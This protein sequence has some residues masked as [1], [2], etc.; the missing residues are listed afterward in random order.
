MIKQSLFDGI[1]K[2]IVRDKEDGDYAY[3]QALSLKLEYV[4]K[5]VTSGVIACIGEDV[6]RH[7]YSLEHQLVR[8]NSIGEW[9]KAL[10][11]A[12]VGPPAQ[13]FDSNG[14]D[15]VRDLTKRV[16]PQDWQYSAVINLNQAAAEVG[17]GS[18]LG[19]KVA[20]R[21]FFDIG[22]R[23]RNRSRGHGATTNDQC[24]RACSRLA[25]SLDAVVGEFRLFELPW[26]Y[27]HRNLSGKYRVSTLLG[28]TSD[29]DHLK[30]ERDVKLSNGVFLYLGR[31]VHVPLVFSD[32]DVLDIALPNGNHQGGTFESLSYVTNEVAR[33]DGSAWSDTPARLPQSETEGSAVLEP[34]GNTFTNVPP[35]FDGYIP[36]SDLE[37]RL[38]KELLESDR[39]RIISLTGPGGIGKTAIAISAIHGIAKREPTPYEVIL[40]ISA[41]DIDLLEFGPKPVS[42]RV[43]TQQDISRAAVELLGPSNSSSEKLEPET[44]FQNCL[45]A[46]AAGPTLFVLDNFETVQSPDDVFKWIDTHIRPP[47]KVLITTRFRDFNG[48]YAIKI[49]G[50]TDE[51]AGQLVDQHAA[52]LKVTALLGSNYKRELIRE[53]DGHP[54]VMKILLGQVAKE[55]HAV[56]PERIVASA[57]DLLKALFERT[58]GALSPGGQRVFLLLCSWRVFVPEVAVEAVLLRPGIER[59]DV[60]EALRELHR[61]SLVDQIFSEEKG[62]KKEAFVGVPLAAAMYGRSKL[63]VSPFKVEV[64]E[65]RKLLMEFGAG[66]KEAVGRGVF[67]RIENLIRAVAVRASTSPKTLEEKL[68]VLEYLATRVPK[69]YLQLSDLVREVRDL[70]HSTD[71]AKKYVRNYLESA[72]TPERLEAWRKLA[73]LCQSSQDPVGELHALS[74]AALLVASDQEDLGHFANRLNNRIRDLKGHS[75]ED[76]WSGKVRGLLERVIEAMEKHFKELSATNC[77]RLAWLYLNVGNSGRALDVAKIG[78]ERDPTNEHCQNLIL[79]LDR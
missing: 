68:P 70:E 42:P 8:T 7:R 21:Q 6:D 17:A 79:K 37:D 10:D 66:K 54:Y 49:G 29:F 3:F 53:S 59:F 28:D 22:V 24:S 26:V 32:P 71:R 12:L 14:R 41:R 5:I 61:F 69:T 75:S 51:Q 13:F 9:V 27:L 30:R 43:I 38:Q 45:A 56:K 78:S 20:L 1:D 52:R 2:R 31:P 46:G 4:T 40:W 65:D 23:L 25:A 76:T 34:L 55:G 60:T 73:D 16:G 77:S 72:P 35:R 11:K 48:D 58:Y 57:D 33:Q 62:E 67:P 36:R 74:E 44:F 63:E 15:L 64:E 50:M 39:H 18:R 19:G 47:N